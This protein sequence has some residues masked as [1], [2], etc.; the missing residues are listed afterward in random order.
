M[1]T[2]SVE[3]VWALQALVGVEQMPTTLHLKPYIPSAHGDL[4]VET[5]Q[6]RGPLSSTAQYHSLVQ[7]GVTDENGRVDTAVRDWM[8]VLGRPDREVALIIR[9]PDQPAT[10]ETG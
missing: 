9:R 5:T 6:G 2:T 8:T 4:I 7:A 1:L 10:A 3:C